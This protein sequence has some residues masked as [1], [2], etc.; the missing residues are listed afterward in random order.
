MKV[1][2]QTALLVIGITGFVFGESEWKPFDYLAV[3]PM[4]K[5]QDL[6]PSLSVQSVL[7]EG[8]GWE[9]MHPLSTSHAFHVVISLTGSAE[10]GRR[11]I[12]IGGQKIM[13]KAQHQT[14]C[15]IEQGNGGF[16]DCALDPIKSRIF[17]TN[18]MGRVSLSIPVEKLEDEHVAPLLIRSDFMKTDEWYEVCFQSS[19]TSVRMVAHVD[20]DVHSKLAKIQP[21]QILKLNSQISPS[22]ALSVSKSVSYLMSLSHGSMPLASNHLHH[23]THQI[24]ARSALSQEIDD[25]KHPGLVYDPLKN[26]ISTYLVNIPENSAFVLKRSLGNPGL[27]HKREPN[28]QETQHIDRLLDASNFNLNSLGLAKRDLHLVDDSSSTVIFGTPKSKALVL[29]Q[30]EDSW[31]HRLVETM[32]EA[33]KL[34]VGIFKKIGVTIMVCFGDQIKILVHL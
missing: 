6:K 32:E 33:W 8:L 30:E 25:E 19:L 16:D 31:K 3:Q 34:V 24:L 1:S 9:D 27:L 17:T 18:S 28:S 5:I 20:A 15:L 14:P 7:A 2:L 21:E 12:P 4:Q 23:D 10:Q 13:I 11:E 29:V 26:H 22:Q